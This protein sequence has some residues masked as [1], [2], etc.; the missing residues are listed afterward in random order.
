M[1]RRAPKKDAITVSVARAQLKALLTNARTLDHL[2]VETLARSY[3]VPLKEI[4]Y[5]LTME[6]KQ[7][8]ARP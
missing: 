4:E 8:E 7:R 6:R 5:L 3:R 2:T 1:F